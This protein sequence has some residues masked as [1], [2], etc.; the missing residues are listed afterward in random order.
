MRIKL[1]NSQFVD[2]MTLRMKAVE[3]WCDRFVENYKKSIEI[4][5]AKIKMAAG[6]K[7]AISTSVVDTGAGKKVTIESTGKFATTVGR[8]DNDD[9]LPA[10]NLDSDEASVGKYIVEDGFPYAST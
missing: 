2:D 7:G 10:A 9:F 3:K 6:Q 1:Q 5:A 8:M 4:E